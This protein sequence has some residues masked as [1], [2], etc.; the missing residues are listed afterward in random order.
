MNKTHRFFL[1]PV[2]ILEF[3]LSCNLILV[4]EIFGPILM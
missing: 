2:G 3:K 1:V 4:Y